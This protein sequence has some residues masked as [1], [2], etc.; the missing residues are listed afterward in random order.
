MNVVRLAVAHRSARYFGFCV[1]TVLCTVASSINLNAAEPAGQLV[2]FSRSQLIIT[3]GNQQCTLFDVYVAAT[4]EQRAQGLMFVQ[5]MDTYEGMIFL[6]PR[7]ARISMWMKNTFIP[8]DMLFIDESGA[9]KA[10]H[11][12]AVPQSTAVIDSGVSVTRVL[13]LNGGT[14]RAF[15][16]RVNDRIIFPFGPR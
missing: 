1:V 5:E 15:G 7:P 6:Y 13:E 3:T 11:T 4:A 14:V 12:D 10:I 9:I 16:I 8:L 2:G